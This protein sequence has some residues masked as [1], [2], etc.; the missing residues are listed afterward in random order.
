MTP[1]V[2]YAL[3]DTAVI[4]GRGEDPLVE[5]D[6]RSWSHQRLLEEVAALG[7]VLRHLGLRPGAPV[8]VDLRCGV[9]AIVTALAAA[10]IGGVVTTTDDPQ[11]SVV[12]VSADSPVAGEGRV[13]LVRGQDVQEPDLD[14]V[15]MIRAGRT[16]PAAAA[17][18]DPAAPYSPGR[19]VAEQI[20]ALASTSAPY[21]A[22]GLRDLLQ[23]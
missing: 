1:N 14:W 16:D 2:S 10:R 23:V 6:G 8:V 11:A 21:D 5:E 22:A 3:L 15:V 18:L 12:V 13:R 7:G 9:D 4:A 17:V 19:T 20:A